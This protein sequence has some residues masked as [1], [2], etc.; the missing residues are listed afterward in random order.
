MR[1]QPMTGSHVESSMDTENDLPTSDGRYDWSDYEDE[2][3][4]G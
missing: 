3:K 1:E 4:P 2:P